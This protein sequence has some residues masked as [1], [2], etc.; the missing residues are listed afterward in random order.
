[1]HFYKEIKIK[2]IYD[3]FPF[4][5]GIDNRWRKLNYFKSLEYYLSPIFTANQN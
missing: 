4:G 2:K 5:I 3:F 1:M